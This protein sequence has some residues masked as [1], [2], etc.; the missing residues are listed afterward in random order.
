MAN[1]SS[2]TENRAAVPSDAPATAEVDTSDWP[3]QAADTIERVIGR[4]AT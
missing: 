1:G 2:P 4:S 3:A